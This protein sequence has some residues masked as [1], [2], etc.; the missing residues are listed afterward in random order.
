MISAFRA[1]L[2]RFG[3]I[4]GKTVEIEYRFA[5]SKRDGYLTS[6]NWSV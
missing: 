3:Y 2:A 4:E 5:G 1:G 6:L